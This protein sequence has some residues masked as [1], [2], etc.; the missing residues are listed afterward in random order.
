MTDITE[1][2]KQLQQARLQCIDLEEEMKKLTVLKIK[3]ETERQQMLTEMQT[4]EKQIGEMRAMYD[5][6]MR[7]ISSVTGHSKNQSA[8]L[9]EPH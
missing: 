4:N 7:L 1:K 3:F 5:G 6:Q 8:L 9:T 2:T